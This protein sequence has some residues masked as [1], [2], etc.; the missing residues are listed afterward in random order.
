LEQEAIVVKALGAGLWQLR[1]VVVVLAVAAVVAV[2]VGRESRPAYASHTRML[3]NNTTIG[4][5]ALPAGYVLYPGTASTLHVWAKDVDD[6]QGAGHFQVDLSYVSW[7]Y[8]VEAIPPY[9]T[10][11]GSTGRAVT[12]SPQV[13]EPN[14]DTGQGHAAISCNTA[15]PAPPAGPQGSGRLASLTLR[16]GPV[17]QT[18]TLTITSVSNVSDT[19]E[20]IPPST[21]IEPA[22]LPLARINLTITVALCGDFDGNGAVTISDILHEGSKFG[23]HPGLPTWN[24]KYDMDA[25]NAVAIAD[26][27]I[28]A[29]Q[30]GRQ[31]TP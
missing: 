10:W 8:S 5:V 3:I 28:V 22:P 14:L 1:R 6:P 17:L 29:R 20:L 25:N 21:V 15:G 2:L 7:L 27:L 30:F 23:L 4:S 16:G 11:L 31:C 12:C 26:I 19:G 24:P 13:I 18:S 9:T